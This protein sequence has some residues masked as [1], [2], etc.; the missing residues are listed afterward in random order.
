VYE[1]AAAIAFFFAAY[2]A[3]TE[4]RRQAV[5]AQRKLEDRRPRIAFSV[6]SCRAKMW[7]YESGL[8]TLAH[9]GGDAA[10]FIQVQP[11][12]SVRGGK[13]W[14][15]FDQVDFLDRARNVAHPDFELDISGSEASPDKFGNLYYVF[16]KRE[17]P[18]QKT[19]NYRIKITFKWNEKSLEENLILRWNVSSEVLTTHPV[20]ST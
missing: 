11:V 19:I 10:Q 6:A 14:I 12:Q 4:Q 13:L 2:S 8:F 9:L 5:E 15:T 7:R 18:S 1:A 3:W 20:E 17:A 16:F